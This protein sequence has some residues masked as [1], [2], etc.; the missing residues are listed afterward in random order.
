M[1]K[2]Y[3]QVRGMHLR[4]PEGVY[5]TARSCRAHRFKLRASVHFS[6]TIRPMLTCRSGQLFVM[7]LYVRGKDVGAGL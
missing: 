3:L 4:Q 6:Y 1:A 2:M 7:P 5:G